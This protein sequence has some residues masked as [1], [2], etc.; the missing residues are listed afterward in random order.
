MY[1]RS[2]LNLGKMPSCIMITIQDAI[3]I[4]ATAFIAGTIAGY[5]GWVLI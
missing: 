2:A 5:L 3:A 1:N 4:T